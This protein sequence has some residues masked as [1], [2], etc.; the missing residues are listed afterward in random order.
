[1]FFL[2]IKLIKATILTSD[3]SKSAEKLA[4]KERRYL[5]AIITILLF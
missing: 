1:M 3:L 2:K 4:N 5:S